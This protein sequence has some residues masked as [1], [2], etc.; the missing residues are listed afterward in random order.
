MHNKIWNAGRFVFNAL[1]KSP[2]QAKMPPI[3]TPADEYI[4]ARMRQTVRDVNRLFESYQ[5]GEAGR[6]IYEFFWSEFADKYIEG[7]K[8]Q[9]TKGGDSAFYTTWTLVRVLDKCLRMLH[10]FTPYV[11]EELWGIHKE[12]MHSKIKLFYT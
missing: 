8:S 4:H 11:T 5:F 9:L 12:N 2:A 10:P 3:W 6:Q 7:A 1:E